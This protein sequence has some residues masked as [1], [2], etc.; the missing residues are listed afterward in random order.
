MNISGEVARTRRW[1]IPAYVAAG[2]AGTPLL[3]MLFGELGFY[4]AAFAMII[5]FCI[6]LLCIKVNVEYSADD[7]SITFTD[8]SGRSRTVKYKDIVGAEFSSSISSVYRDAY[9]KCITGTVSFRAGAKRY[10]FTS[11][12]LAEGNSITHSDVG[13]KAAED[14]LDVKTLYNMIMERTK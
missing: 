7:E 9:H 6:L 13:F 14:Q 1:L 2:A 4:E 12:V 11:E 3:N 5:L 8:D 10:R